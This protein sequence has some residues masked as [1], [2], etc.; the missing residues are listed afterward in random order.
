[1]RYNRKHQF[2]I[3][4]NN[5]AVTI[6]HSLER[7]RH[8]M[9]TWRECIGAVILSGFALYGITVAGI[10]MAF[11]WDP[12]TPLWGQVIGLAFPPVATIVFGRYLWRYRT[13]QYRSRL[14]TYAGV[15][16]LVGAIVFLAP[17]FGLTAQQII[18]E[19]PALNEE[20]FLSESWL[21][22]GLVGLTTGHIYGIT[23]V[24]RLKLKR[25]HDATRDLILA[26]DTAEVAERTV[27][28]AERILG[29]DTSGIYVPGDEAVLDPIAATEQ[30]ADVFGRIPTIESR[31]SIAWEAYDSNEAVFVDDVRE[32]AEVY[33]PETP[34]RSEMI[35]PI[36]DYGVFLAASTEVSAFDESDQMLAQVLISNAEAAFDRVSYEATLRKRERRL[37]SVQER[38]ERLMYTQTREETAQVAIEA[39]EEV[40]GATLSGVY[41]LSE[42]GDALEHIAV[43]AEAS[44]RLADALRYH[45][46][47]EQKSTD[48]VVREAL[49]HGESIYVEDAH[50]HDALPDDLSIRCLLVY[51]V[52]DY[53]VFVAAGERPHEFDEVERTLSAVLVSVLETALDRA[54]REQALQR[55][56]S[57]LEQHRQRLTVL[58]RV[59]RHDIRN[60]AS[61]ILG[62]L[63]KLAGRVGDDSAFDAI[64]RQTRKIVELSENARQAERT[65]KDID[66]SPT[67]T[68]VTTLVE[69][70]I[71]DVRSTWPNVEVRADTPAQAHVASNGLIETAIRNVI[72]NAAEHN[73]NSSPRVEVT[74]SS[75]L[76]DDELLIRIADNGPGIP[77]YE[78]EVLEQRDETKLQHSSGL[79]LWLVHWIIEDVD[80]TVDIE[81]RQPSGTVV[82]LRVPQPI[83]QGVPDEA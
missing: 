8:T 49:E 4:S 27:S 42:T 21:G 28:S 44:G 67:P 7:L 56:E 79:G 60:T 39:A 83:A 66:T 32:H 82:R 52:G 23:Q 16:S 54:E 73:D 76:D 9:A 11:D 30:T 78:R 24:E 17:G 6:M 68:E 69:S 3:I 45:W 75:D 47:N 31:E 63:S 29:L 58:N 15:G 33:N 1:M 22:G 77:A 55:N 5:S 57:R 53:G 36:D 26:S 40:I 19:Q 18:I 70:I 74:V 35:I 2:V 12:L 20:V 13:H 48:A 61:L 51:P 46:T 62:E 71:E 81:Q 37:K 72:M 14:Y 41:F 80:G 64:E 65:V 59:L 10:V 34:V 38:L 25:L 43:S 50:M